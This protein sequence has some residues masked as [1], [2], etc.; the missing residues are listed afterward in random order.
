MILFLLFS[1]SN[2]ILKFLRALGYVHKIIF[3]VISFFHYHIF[4]IGILKKIKHR[5]H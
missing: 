2:L 1:P 3:I 4:Y 5:K